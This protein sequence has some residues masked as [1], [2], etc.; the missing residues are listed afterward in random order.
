MFQTKVEEKIKKIK[1]YRMCNNV[2]LKIVS[3]MK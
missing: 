3:F 2:F 1:M